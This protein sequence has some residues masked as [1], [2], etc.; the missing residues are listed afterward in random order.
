MSGITPSEQLPVPQALA[1]GSPIGGTSVTG[2]EGWT[3]HDVMRVLR[4]R[5]VMI[6]V[7]TIVFYIL[8]VA[9][10]ILI[11]IFAPAYTS[12]ALLELE[13]PK[14]GDALM[15]EDRE[16]NKDYMERLL[17]TEVQKLRSQALM[18]KIVAL[19]EFKKTAYYRWY[20]SNAGEAAQGLQ[21]DV[22][23]APIRETQMIRVALSCREKVEAQEIVRWIVEQYTTMFTDSSVQEMHDRV[24]SLEAT[25][26]SLE[27]QLE[28]KRSQLRNLR[29]QRNLPM[30]E[31]RRNEAREHVVYL[32]NQ[33]SEI[34]AAVA[35]LQAQ[36]DTLTNVDPSR[37][38]L[39]AEDEL[40]IE[41]DPILRFWRSQAENLDVQIQAQMKLFG[42]NHRAVVMLRKQRDGY[43]AKENAKREELI[44]RIRKRRLESLQQQ[45]AQTR[46]VQARLM[47]QYQQ[48]QAEEQDLDRAMLTFQQMQEDKDM[49]AQ[50]ISEVQTRLTEARHVVSDKTR[51]RLHVRQWPI[52]A[53]EPSRPVYK[54][55]LSA[56]F[57]LA[58]LAAIGVAFLRELTDQ[59]IRT[60]VDVARHGRLSVLGCVPLLDDEEAEEVETIE[61]A[62]RR[63][64]HSL[65]AEAFRRVRTNLQFSGPAESQRCLLITSPGPGD[66][67]TAVAVNL[68]YT[69]AHDQQRVLLIDCNFRRPAIHD[70]FAQTGD[71]GLSHILVGRG[72]L[73][74]LVTRTEVPTLD[75]LCSGPM[76]PTPAEL[77][78]SDRMRALLAEAVKQYDRVLLD[79]P[80]TLLISDATVLAMQVDGVVLVARADENTRGALKR[81]KEQLDAIHARTIGAII[82]AV[83]ARAGGYFREQYREFYEYMGDATVVA[84]LPEPQGGPVPPV[85]ADSEESDAD[86]PESPDDA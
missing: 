42:P 23:I 46:N 78:G 74:D 25:L 21:D 12:E 51:Q 5:K 17:Q 33:I 85:G 37:L 56:G 61:D 53:V 43:Y 30:A 60:P 76:P 15:P 77:L 84:E 24:A 64:P 34:D 16:V 58:L 81:T 14:A 55:Y 2:G 83:K 52:L 29:E 22:S 65:I 36:L 38:P 4:Q 82:N 62:V 28:T 68:A 50:Q 75:V 44:D 63:A 9:A 13:P 20:D 47:D 45:L 66:G 80:P 1:I 10:T 32:R 35:S 69:L 59:V 31:M 48:V 79:G 39:T 54:V 73:E 72:Q 6:I 49:L 3:F 26:A 67:K 11:G 27:E 18:A 86:K 70:L 8:V 57:V 71:K 7:L 19:P 40:I 41:S